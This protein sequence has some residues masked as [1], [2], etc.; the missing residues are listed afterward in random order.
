LLELPNLSIWINSLKELIGAAKVSNNFKKNAC[1]MG[2]LK[3][4][5][6]HLNGGLRK[7]MLKQRRME[8]KKQFFK[9]EKIQHAHFHHLN[10]GSVT[11]L[12]K[13]HSF[14]V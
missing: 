12:L 2:F 5:A 8:V 11:A 1:G 10:G 4:S 13:Q 3:K 6:H 9:E 7:L 14:E